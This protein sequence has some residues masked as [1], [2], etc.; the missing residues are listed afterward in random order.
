M[1]SRYVKFVEVTLKG[2]M[3][4]H[5]LPTKKT[6]KAVIEASNIQL[7]ITIGA[8]LDRSHELNEKLYRA[9][10]TIGALRR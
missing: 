7:S 8:T 4:R 5:T 3:L 9:V 10:T 1:I 2:F 6:L